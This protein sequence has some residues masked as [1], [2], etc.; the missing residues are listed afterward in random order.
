MTAAA[1]AAIRA[2]YADEVTARAGSN[3]VRAAFATV[4]RERF[5]GPGRWLIPGPGGYRPTPD[6]DPARIYRHVLAALDAEAGIDR[7]GGMLLVTRRPRGLAA[8]FL[9]GSQ[10]I[11]R[12]GAWSEP[13]ADALDGDADG[14][15]RVTGDG[16]W[17]STA[18][19]D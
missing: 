17:L 4:P 11:P 18:P 10:F 2:R 7:R 14:S 13:D 9:C 3:G 1:T 19:V 5:L 12:A 15:A 8:R 16:G 6:S